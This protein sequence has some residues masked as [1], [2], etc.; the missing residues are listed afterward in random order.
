Q[1]KRQIAGI[2]GTV[3][4]LDDL[5]GEAAVAAAQLGSAQPELLEP[6]EAQLGKQVQ[7]TEVPPAGAQLGHVTDHQGVQAWRGGALLVEEL[8]GQ[9]QRLVDGSC[10]QRVEDVVL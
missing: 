5:G 2:G 7:R 1:P 6:V 9:P 8:G 3:A 10:Q 4:L